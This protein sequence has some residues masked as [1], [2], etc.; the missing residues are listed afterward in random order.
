[1]DGRIKW[2]RG[3]KNRRG[4]R[5]GRQ[6]PVKS[7]VQ[8]NCINARQRLGLARILKALEERKIS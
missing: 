5:D 4:G 8:Q 2:I 1:M 6:S 7:F 3:T